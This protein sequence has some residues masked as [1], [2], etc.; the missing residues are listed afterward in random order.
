M[1][2]MSAWQSDHPG[3]IVGDG[4]SFSFSTSRSTLNVLHILCIGSILGETAAFTEKAI[5]AYSAHG[6]TFL[7]LAQ[8]LQAL[9]TLNEAIWNRF[10]GT[11]HQT[12]TLRIGLLG[13]SG[14]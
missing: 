7:R 9:Q 12:S 4:G 1:E 13:L 2:G 11:K 6:I 3:E 14:C 5:P 10:E 8:L